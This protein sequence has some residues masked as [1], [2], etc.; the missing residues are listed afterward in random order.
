MIE[1]GVAAT[2]LELAGE[3][4]AE[5]GVERH[6]HASFFPVA[7]RRGD[8]GRG[9]H[10]PPPRGGPR[11]RRAHRGRGL[12]GP[13]GGARA[14]QR[15]ARLLHARPR[16]CSRSSSRP[17]C[18]RSPTS[19]RF[20]SPRASAAR[21]SPSPS[22]SRSRPQSPTRSRSAR[23]PIP[24][25]ASAGCRGPHGRCGGQ[26]PHHRGRP[27]ARGRPRGRA[28]AARAARHP[29]RRRPAAHRPRRGAGRAHARDGL[30]L[31][32]RIHPGGH[33]ARQASPPARAL[34][35]TTRACTPSRSRSPRRSSA[36]CCAS[37]LLPDP[38]RGAWPFATGASGRSNEVGGDF[39]DVFDAGHGEWAIVIG[40]VVGKGAEAA[41]ITALVRATLQAA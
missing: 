31:R 4:P 33:R 18:P 25:P 6:W 9:R 27:A 38:G 34:R 29:L 24:A 13:G 32:A 7:R 36:R 26:R 8:R 35:S 12:A 1:T 19:A 39:Y 20:I 23:P 28:R 37:E 2:E 10:G 14:R 21:R 15:G 5:P 41:A 11:A 16:A 17:W 40:D 3:T 22:P 30:G